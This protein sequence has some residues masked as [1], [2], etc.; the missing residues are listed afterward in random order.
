MI[1]P[2][3]DIPVI[4]I[5]GQPTGDDRLAEQGRG[6]S[7]LGG[8]LQKRN[9]DSPAATLPPD[10]EVSTLKACR[11]AFHSKCLAS[12]F[13]NGRRD[14]PTCRCYYCSE[15]VTDWPDTPPQNPA[16]AITMPK[17][18][19]LRLQKPTKH[20]GIDLDSDGPKHISLVSLLP[21]ELRRKR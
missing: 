1:C 7:V 12:W 15:Q 18:E 4:A 5:S 14:C 11:H 19:Q 16:S 20:T 10:K 6:E 9:I 17:V 3:E 8:T 21:P 2:D 13:V